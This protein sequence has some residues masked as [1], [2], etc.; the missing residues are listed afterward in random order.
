MEVLMNIR[1]LAAMLLVFAGCGNPLVGEDFLG[2]PLFQFQGQVMSYLGV[3]SEGHEFRVSLFWSPTGETRVPVESLV[4][5]TSASVTIQFPSTFEINV[6][7]PPEGRHLVDS[8]P[9]YGLAL[10]LVYED[11]DDNGRLTQGS[12]PSELVGGAVDQV[13]MYASRKLSKEQSPTGLPMPS[14][15]SIVPIPLNCEESFQPTVGD[16]ACG[17]ELGM[18]CASDADCSDSGTCMTELGSFDVPGGYCTLEDTEG[19]CE[20][21]GGVVA[22]TG[23]AYWLKACITNQD[24]LRT[25]YTCVDLDYRLDYSCKACW[26]YKE[27]PIAASYC[28][29]YQNW[30]ADPECGENLGHP[31]LQDSDCA[32]VLDDGKCLHELA[33][34]SF[35]EG[36]CTHADSSFGCTPQDGRYLIVYTSFWF[37]QCESANDCRKDEGYTCDPV[38]RMCIPRF[39]MQLDIQPHFRV[40]KNVESLCF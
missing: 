2:D 37:R 40:E 35:E 13:L 11:L 3:P 19:G 6:F 9:P 32:N 4:E 22:Q 16:Q 8:D 27:H 34:V 33:D 10:V 31:C 15:F 24:C 28:T 25:G 21:A 1:L 39:P 20:P 38:F 26:P 30:Y 23:E 12:V 17:P 7:Y 5:Q 18:G 29:S 14:G 36:Y